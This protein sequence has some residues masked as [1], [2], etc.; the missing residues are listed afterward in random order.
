MSVIS[1]P[2]VPPSHTILSSGLDTV[3][4]KDMAKNLAGSARSS[5]Q[6]LRTNVSVPLKRA[7]RGGVRPA[8]C[9]ASIRELLFDCS[10]SRRPSR[11]PKCVGLICAVFDEIS[12]HSVKG[13][14][15]CNLV[16]MANCPCKSI[17]RSRSGR[18]N[19][20]KR[21]LSDGMVVL[22]RSALDRTSA[23]GSTEVSVNSCACV[24]SD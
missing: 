18:L 10:R 11:R 15:I 14:N 8:A 19:F 20:K 9:R 21:K 23:C 16:F 2:S 5:V 7:L 3:A 22:R 17:M 24:S 12:L 1:F 13:G 4:P 6:D